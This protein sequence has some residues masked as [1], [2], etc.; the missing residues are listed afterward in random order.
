MLTAF[1]GLVC[2]CLDTP[3][4]LKAGK[5]CAPHIR[6]AVSEDNIG[7]HTLD[8]L[9][10]AQLIAGLLDTGCGSIEEVQANF[11]CTGIAGKY[12]L[13]IPTGYAKLII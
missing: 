5:K 8:Q 9:I 4:Y 11:R 3:F 12:T 13:I 2:N 1:D 6:G 10:T 7:K